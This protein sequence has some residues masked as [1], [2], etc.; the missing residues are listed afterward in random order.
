MTELNHI[1]IKNAV[2]YAYHGAL[3]DEQNLG[4]KFE[5]DVDMYCDLSAAVE[6]DSLK[7]TVDY[8]KVYSFIQSLALAKKYHLLEALAN[9]IGKGLLREFFNIE[10][11]TV[12]I[13]K[14]HP[15]VK[16][17]VDHVEVEITQKR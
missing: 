3:A 4:G 10:V 6:S 8:E 11:V 9:T 13:R 2:F 17:V 7:R 1:R 15:P 14:P 16:G 12:R 5:I